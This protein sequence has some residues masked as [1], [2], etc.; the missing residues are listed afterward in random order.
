[1][2]FLLLRFLLRNLLMFWWVYFYVFFSLIVFNI[3]FLFSV[4]VVSMITCYGEVLFW[5][6]LFGVPEA[7]YTWMGKTFFRFGKVYVFF[8]LHILHIPL[9][10]TSSPLVPMILRFYLLMESVAYS[11]HSS[12]IVWLR[13]LLFS[14]LISISLLSSEILCSTCYSL[15]ER[16]STVFFLSH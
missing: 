5:S 3:L 11:F 10:C 13:F 1:M 15:L 4:L 6:S 7:S 14:S 12:W 8:L 9:A 16:I 2:F